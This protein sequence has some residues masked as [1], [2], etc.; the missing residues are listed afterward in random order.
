MERGDSDESNSP[1]ETG[2]TTVLGEPYAVKVARTVR[3]GGVD[4]PSA[5]GSL[6]HL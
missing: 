6:L 1:S 2:G 5:F 3:E 4:A